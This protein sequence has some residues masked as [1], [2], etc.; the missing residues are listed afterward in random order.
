MSGMKR[1]RAAVIV[2]VSLLGLA[3]CGAS[4][5]HGARAHSKAP[6]GALTINIAL[7][8]EELDLPNGLHVVLHQERSSALSLVYVRSRNTGAKDYQQWLE[9]VGGNTNASTDLDETDY[10]AYVP[11]SALPRAIWLEADRMA[12]PLA[13]L[14]E[15]GF[16]HERDVVKNEWREHYE[17]V[18]FGN[19][20]A[21][22]REAV[23]G[24][25]H[26]YGS[27]TIGRGA[28]LDKATLEEARAFARAYYRPNNATL[29][30]AGVFDPVATRALVTRYFATIPAGPAAP[31]R[32]LPP[33]KPMASQRIDVAAAVDGP[34]V[35]IAWPAPATHADGMEE[36]AY[37]LGFFSG[38]VRRR[39]ITEKKIA[40]EVDVHYEHARLGGLASI[41]VKLKPGESPDTTI[42]VID[43]YLA[44]AARLGRRWS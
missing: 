18:P 32:S 7:P 38:R 27:T 1:A 37:G 13:P 23:Y 22:A 10:H 9:D 43:E 20:R 26:P 39:L 34:A 17:D 11:P 41:V 29:V 15:A 33:A 42:S 25:A 21:F 16:A 19:L 5:A 40:N 31:A 24:A 6:E 2:A 12:Y 8:I 35:M 28:D 14:D 3:G 4:G 30:I 36:I 44:E